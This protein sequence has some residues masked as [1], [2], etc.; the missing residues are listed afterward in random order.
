MDKLQRAARARSLLEDPILNEA[1]SVLE[2]TQI[3]VFTSL[4]CSDEQLREAHRMV[5]ALRSVKEQLGTI[6][7]DGRLLERR[8]EKK[9]QDRV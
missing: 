7:T 8:M 3:A 1:F 2:N 9:G 4:T 6:V 5:R